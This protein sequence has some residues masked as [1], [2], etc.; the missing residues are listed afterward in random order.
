MVKQLPK[1]REQTVTG[2]PDRAVITMNLHQYVR[3]AMTTQQ[4]QFP[5]FTQGLKSK[6]SQ[7]SRR[8]RRRSRNVISTT[9]SMD[10]TV[11][12]TRMFEI[13]LCVFVPISCQ[14]C[15][16]RFRQTFSSVCD[17]FNVASHVMFLLCC[18]S[19]PH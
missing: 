12:V 4:G 13:S 15:F 18:I 8:R 16:T 2:D 3:D 5:S 6:I 11:N 14:C 9:R 1:V 17:S 19:V 7:C 10:A